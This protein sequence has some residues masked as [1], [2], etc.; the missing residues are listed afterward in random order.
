MLLCPGSCPFGLGV[1]LGCAGLGPL[2]AV[3]PPAPF[4][5]FAGVT[6]LEFRAKGNAEA[7]KGE[8]RKGKGKEKGKGKG[9]GNEKINKRNHREERSTDG[10]DT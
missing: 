2:F 7:G 3:L 5:S 4:G 9:K 10:K 6:G 1:A 8:R